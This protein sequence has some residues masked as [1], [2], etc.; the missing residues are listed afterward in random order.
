MAG[1]HSIDIEVNVIDNVTSA[2][3]PIYEALERISELYWVCEY[4]G[5]SNLLGFNVCCGCTHTRTFAE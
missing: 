5:N 3:Q 1:M 2:L 4:C